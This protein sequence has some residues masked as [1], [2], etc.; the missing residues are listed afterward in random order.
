MRLLLVL[1][2]SLTMAG[3]V[4]LEA[5]R[6]DGPSGMLLW[7]TEPLGPIYIPE[8][9]SAEEREAAE[10]LADALHKVSGLNWEIQAEG[11]RLGGRGIYVGKTRQA[12]IHR[13]WPDSGFDECI[14]QAVRGGSL[15]LLGSSPAAHRWAVSDFLQNQ[16]G[17]RWFIPGDLGE[18]YDPQSRLSIPMLD[19]VFYPSFQDRMLPVSRSKTARE[20]GR[21]NYLIQR[22]HFNHNLYSFVPVSLF[23][24][25]PELFPVIEGKR[26]AV[27]GGRAPQPNIAY[28]ETQQF[29]AERINEQFRE[30]SEQISVSIAINDS[31]LFDET[32]QTQRWLRPFRFF[33]GK[34]D[35][36]NLVF[37]FSN[38]VARRV[39]EEHPDRYLTQLSYYFTENVPDFPVQRNL[40]PYLTFD[41]AQW[42][43][44]EQEADDKE[45]VQRWQK[46]GPEFLGTWDYYEG[47]P[48]FIP[49]YYPG[50]VARSLRFLHQHGVRNFFA[51]GGPIWGFDGPRLWLAAQ[52]L[53]DVEQNPAAL[54][55]E[56]FTRF[57]GPAAEPM[58][59]FFDRCEEIWMG[60]PP[61]GYW[62]KYYQDP[63]QA[64]LFPPEVCAELVGYLDAAW[65][66]VGGDGGDVDDSLDLYRKRVEL[67]RKAFA[68]TQAASGYYHDWWEAAREAVPRAEQMERYQMRLPKL[69]AVWSGQEHSAQMKVWEHL[70]GNDPSARGTDAPVNGRVL[71]DEDFGKLV[72]PEEP[73]GLGSLGSWRLRVFHKERLGVTAVPA[74]GAG[75]GYL[76]VEGAGFFSLYQWLP[77]NDHKKVWVRLP[78]RGR[79]SSGCQVF[80]QVSFMDEAGKVLAETWKDRLPTGSYSG[81]MPLTLQ[82]KVPKGAAWFYVGVK[83]QHQ[84]DG[85]WLD[86]D[87]IRVVLE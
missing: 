78:V 74:V 80:L 24:E 23:P 66:R 2:L 51:E 87:G 7:G 13:L 48:Y 44:P 27:S 82:G 72:I 49:R 1:G 43:D 68:V 47:S 32:E 63:A 28:P 39:A 26:Q 59:R 57:Y 4:F 41:R 81:W 86:L 58:R 56:Y 15:F 14:V 84:F 12:Y 45:T 34:P 29:I 35:Y 8:H 6:L 69:Q 19:R 21:N 52:L 5:G 11:G 31:T 77:V 73:W 76:R 53:W 83:I 67:T 50:L 55:N 22:F 46:A 79:V 9:A 17:M 75:E 37:H 70:T 10:W 64:E 30:K 33:R 61:P 42:F 16:V 25:R 3:P 36:S 60:Q 40:I 62:L 71:L 18:V 54:L 65:R 85:D 20:W 38:E